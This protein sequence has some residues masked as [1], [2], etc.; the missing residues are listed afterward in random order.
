MYPNGVPPRG[1]SYRAAAPIRAVAA[2]LGEGVSEGL[3]RIRRGMHQARTPKAGP[4]YGHESGVPLEFDEADLVLDD[5][6]VVVPPSPPAPA[7][8]SSFAHRELIAEAEGGW[9]AEDRQA[10]DD[11][12]GFD[13][14]VV[15]DLDEDQRRA[16]PVPEPTRVPKAKKKGGKK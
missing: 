6:P 16:P 11:A 3:G 14:F 7:P 4:G 2:G 15:G 13:D 12:E 5:E 1:S 10:I 9:D 8:A